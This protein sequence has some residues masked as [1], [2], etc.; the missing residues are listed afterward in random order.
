MLSNPQTW[1]RR[2]RGKPWLRALKPAIGILILL[3]AGSSG[4]DSPAVSAETSDQASGVAVPFLVEVAGVRSVAIPTTRS[5]DMG[6]ALR[7]PDNRTRAEWNT[8]GHV[9]NLECVAGGTLIE[10]TWSDLIPG[11]AYS[12]W[13]VKMN[14]TDR[15]P[16]KGLDGS[17]VGTVVNN[18][19]GEAH[20]RITADAL[21]G[22]SATILQPMTSLQRRSGGECSLERQDYTVVASYHVEGSPDAGDSRTGETPALHARANF[23]R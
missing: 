21:G 2:P 17:M 3:V 14:G 23:E 10:A 19:T 12:M 18:T 4:C 20:D 22:A 6:A 7:T 8:T 1:G 5:A 15:G 16:F 11:G 13:S 9:E